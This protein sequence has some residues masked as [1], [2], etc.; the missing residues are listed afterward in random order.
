MFFSGAADVVISAG[1]LALGLAVGSF[2][3]VVIHR[4]PRAGLSVLYPRRSFCPSCQN[5]LTW[6]DNIPVVSYVALRGRCRH[7]D[8]PI[9]A[10]YPLVEILSGALA[11]S[12]FRK[13]GLSWEFFFHWYFVSALTAVAFIDSELMVIPDLLVLPTVLLGLALA[14]IVPNPGLTGGMLWARLSDAGW[15]PRAISLAGGALGFAFGFLS[16]FLASKAYKMW[17]GKD[18]LGSGDPLLLGL[19]GAFLGWRSIF[20]I[21][22]LSSVIGLLSVILSLAAGKL[23]RKGERGAIRIPF[24]PFL[25]LAALFWLFYGDPIIVWYASLFSA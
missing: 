22:F 15:A 1:V 9:S 12:L 17:R 14:A 11:L 10:R 3:N 25:V 7:C 23:P 6:R 20:P 21:L 2:L 24:G 18:G 16:L 8:A 19:I 5:Q 13:Y 4:L